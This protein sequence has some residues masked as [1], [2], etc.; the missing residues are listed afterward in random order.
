MTT[1]TPAEARTLFR[2]SVVVGCTAM[3]LGVAGI[4]H[5]G[6]R[7]RRLQARQ[8]TDLARVLL[9]GLVSPEGVDVVARWEGADGVAHEE[10][11]HV[12]DDPWT[13]F[14]EQAP[15]GV[16]LTLLVYRQE[17]GMRREVWRQPA[18]LTRGG[19]FEAYVRPAA[20]D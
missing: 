10:G 20:S 17:T 16:A 6:E 15:E 4:F 2:A 12:G 3:V 19:L 1:Q 8:P 7:D 14:F 18:L 13:W 5:F 11:G 9:Q